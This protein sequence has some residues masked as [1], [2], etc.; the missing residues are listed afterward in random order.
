M[1]A[2]PELLRE[3]ALPYRL[4]EVLPRWLNEVPLY[5]RL[6][7]LP[8]SARPSVSLDDL[9]RLPLITKYDIRRDFP[10]NFLRAGA[11]LDTLL[12]QDVVELEHTSGTSEE[13]TPLVLGRGWWA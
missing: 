6:R 10:R 13:R 1:L 3:A 5:Q 9:R 12:D 7:P 4:G 11:A 2:T 8:Q